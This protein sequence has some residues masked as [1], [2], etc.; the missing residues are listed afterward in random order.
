MAHTATHQG[1][2]IPHIRALPLTRPL[3]WLA[4]GWH[5]LRRTP[6]IACAYG[7]I[8]ALMGGA[9]T[10]LLASVHRLPWLGPIAF[11]F[12]LLGPI[13]AVGLYEVSRRLQQGQHLQLAHALTA[14][15]AN[16]VQ[17][18]LIGVTLLVVLATWLLLANLISSVF[19]G[20]P[21]GSWQ[22]FYTRALLSPN[23]IP[24]LTVGILVG[25]LF[26]ALAF[27]LTVLS[28]PMLLDRDT[29]AIT[30]MVTSMRAVQRNRGLMAIWGALILL[31]TGVG[32]LTFYLGLIVI[33][34]LIGHA[35][36]HA[37]RDLIAPA[38]Q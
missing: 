25:A 32:L 10:L 7:L 23:G 36:W 26:A 34:P 12:V 3:A 22:E 21:I 15:R 2:E 20:H 14:W 1:L 8:F 4:A 11:S 35:T 17:I 27:S 28:I 24:F 16:P 29:D 5:D 38:P 13:L 30:A 6:L 18:G 33:L 19:F 9:L 37:Y 31:L